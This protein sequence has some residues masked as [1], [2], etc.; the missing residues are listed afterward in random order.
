M[1]KTKQKMSNDILILIESKSID[2]PIIYIKKNKSKYTKVNRSKIFW[3]TRG[4]E[5]LYNT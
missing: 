1:Y 2:R 3:P 4:N 5:E